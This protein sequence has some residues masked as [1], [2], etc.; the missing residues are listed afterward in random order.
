MPETS[1]ARI[2]IIDDQ[3]ATRYILRRILARA[4]YEVIEACTGAEG[5][6]A[7]M[8]FPDVILA[9]VKLPDMLGYEVSRRLRANPATVSIPIVQI[10]A[11][12]TTD[13]SRVQAL[14]GGADTYLTQPVEPAVLLAQVSALLRLRRAESLSSLAAREWQA[15]FDAMSEGLAL[16]D[17]TGILMRANRAF[18][19]L[20][21]FVPSEIEGRAI[22]EVFESRFSISFAEFLTRSASSSVE[23]SSGTCWLRLSYDR[24]QGD[25]RNETGSVLLLADITDYKKL[26]ETVRHSER[27][28]ATG[29]LAHIIAHEINN[30]LEALSNL[31]YLVQNNTP[32]TN[33]SYE[34]VEQASA[35]LKRISEITKQILAYHR[36]SKRPIPTPANELLEGTVAMF[37]AQMLSNRIK[38]LSEIRCTAMVSVHPGEIRQVFGNLISNS[39]DAMGT[40]DGHLRIRCANA[41]D[42]QSGA[43]GVRFTF[44]DNGAGIPPNVL[45]RIF[46]AFYTT[47]DLEGSG[48]GLWLSSEILEKHHGHMKIRTRTEGP[49]RGTLFSIFIPM[50]GSLP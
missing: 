28:A 7:A 1:A 48:I 2:L 40:H 41:S 24:L 50:S 39:L 15:T 4:G 38:L 30:P 12:F 33:P 25:P 36:E 26:Q 20:L 34:F 22:A 14:E 6:E 46:E 17:S 9:D 3:E 23:L 21:H 27:L 32:T 16:V 31:L 42:T 47:K 10:S 49:Y 45:P 43:R 29:R 18:L 11:S 8:A 35:E 5:L 37:R 19:E 44:S 13:E